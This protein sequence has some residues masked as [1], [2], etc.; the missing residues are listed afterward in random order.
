MQQEIVILGVFPVFFYAKSAFNI[1]DR[2]LKVVSNYAT[3]SSFIETA[4]LIQKNRSF[5]LL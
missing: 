2:L 5:F 4:N 3:H 1:Y